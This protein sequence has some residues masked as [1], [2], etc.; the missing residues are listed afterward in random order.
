ME[1]SLFSSG[2]DPVVEASVSFVGDSVV[3]ASVSSGDDSG[4]EASLSSSGQDSVVEVHL[5]SDVQFKITRT[6]TDN[7]DYYLGIIV[8]H[9][10]GLS[11]HVT[12][13]MGKMSYNN[14]Y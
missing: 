5:S 10:S 7:E 12:G 8:A 14:C 4:V 13:V 2:Q 6:R 11:D 3:K 1:A 9:S